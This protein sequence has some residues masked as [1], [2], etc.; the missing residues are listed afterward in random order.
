M[1]EGGRRRDEDCAG[2]AR[3][4]SARFASQEAA[5]WAAPQATDEVADETH[6]PVIRRA[7]ELGTICTHDGSSMTAIT[8]SA[9]LRDV[10]SALGCRNRRQS[11][12]SARRRRGRDCV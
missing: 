2:V 7:C 12:K 6:A 3:R 5:T 11:A 4:Y 9:R 1:F 10:A 8:A